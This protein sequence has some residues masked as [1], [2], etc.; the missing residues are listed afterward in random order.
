MAVL[1]SERDLQKE[2]MKPN[3]HSL[4]STSQMGSVTGFPLCSIF[5]PPTLYS[6]E[7]KDE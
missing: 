2:Y 1:Q 4:F 7:R 3:R 6:K 5:I